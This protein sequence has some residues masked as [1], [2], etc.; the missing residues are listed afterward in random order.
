M[1]Q[2]LFTIVSDA[3]QLETDLIRE[4]VSAGLRNA[5]ACGKELGRQRRIVNQ[6]DII[7]LKAEGASLRQIVEKLGTGRDG[8]FSPAISQVRS[9]AT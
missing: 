3:A 7:R 1:G 6:K 4:R 2:A 8:D 5:R 9:A